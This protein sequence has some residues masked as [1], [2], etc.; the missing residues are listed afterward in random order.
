MIFLD[1]DLWEL[2]SY[3]VTVV[4]LPFAIIVFW[5]EQRKE[6]TNEQEEL[7][8]KLLDE[9]NELA[10]LL[11]DNADLR[12]ISG[13]SNKLE[14]TPEQE[15]KKLIIFDLLV[16]FF[17]RAYILIYEDNMDKQE[18]RMWQTWEDYIDFWLKREDF[19]KVVPELLSGED[20]DF[21]SYMNKKLLK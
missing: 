9:Y 2:L 17:E 16:A 3:I 19:K 20:P 5:L 8:V 11:I 6:R 10:K 13:G 21:V 15:E 4:A 7:F 1:K 12:L 18:S 14:L